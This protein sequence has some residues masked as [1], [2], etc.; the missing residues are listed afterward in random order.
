MP[1]VQRV[2]ASPGC[3]LLGVSA[4]LTGP[5]MPLADTISN[6]PSV[7][8]LGVHDDLAVVRRYLD[9]VEAGRVALWIPWDLGFLSRALDFDLLRREAQRRQLELAIVS[10]DPQRRQLAA[11]CGFAAFGTL[12]G[13]S[14]AQHWNGH[15]ALEVEPP[16]T[17]WWDE[18]VELRRGQV[19]AT[20]FWWQW[21]R[22]GVR[23]VAF[24]LAVVAVVVTAYVMI[25]SAEITVVP[26]T[27]RVT[28][29]VPVSV[30]P[31]VEAVVVLEEGGGILPSRRV[32]LEVE[33]R[34][35]VATTETAELASGRATGE[36]LFTS[37]LAQDY[38]VPAGT[39][40]RTSSTS[41]PIRF[42]T[43]A[44]VVVPAE[45]Q[46]SAP[47]AALDERTGNV[48]AFQ[49]NRVEGVAASAVRVINPAPTTGAEPREVRVVSQS[50]YDRVREQL[51]QQLL[52]SAYGDLHQFLEPN[53]FLPYPSLRV[54]AVPKKVYSHFIG[55]ESD[56][57]ELT[58]R[59]LVS[60]QAVDGDQARAVA[61]EALVDRLPP[62]YQLMEAE[63]EVGDVVEREEGS[64]WFTF[65]VTGEGRGAARISEDAVM[66]QARGK[67]LDEARAALEDALPVAEPPQIVSEPEWP[68]WLEWLRRVPFISLRIDVHIETDGPPAAERTSGAPIPS[69][70]EGAAEA[71]RSP[72]RC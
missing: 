72:G 65:F 46:A 49:I 36:V 58:M 1:P 16:P 10:S 38:V 59:L 53:E 55:E 35:E 21:I 56:S 61:R 71:F 68:A 3:C 62:G 30:D 2:A 67:R 12:E 13:A 63:Y 18:E 11:R 24:V 32:G 47:I 14:A 5:Q 64:G 52:D 8:E 22:D 69:Q 9:Q 60:G 19:G 33:G 70:V 54:E 7:I 26:L 31:A 23:Y 27:E 25:P 34:A 28:A 29:R 41:Y 17:H 43:T 44:D 42:R 51:T 48:G 39:I 20:P 57:V 37:R 4:L 15:V 66:A 50:D 45:G 6:E 40:V